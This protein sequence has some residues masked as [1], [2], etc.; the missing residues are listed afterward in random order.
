VRIVVADALFVNL[1]GGEEGT[2]LG[3]TEW[4]RHIL[5]PL[6]FRSADRSTLKE[7]VRKLEALI[8]SDPR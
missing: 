8:L 7:S 2:I 6:T 5:N 4:Y 1:Q 3:E